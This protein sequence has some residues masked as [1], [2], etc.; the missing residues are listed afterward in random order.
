MT[1]T[2]GAGDEK[3]YPE[4]VDYIE[5][6]LEDESDAE[7]YMTRIIEMELLSYNHCYIELFFLE[8]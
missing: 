6:L 3:G 1:I 5:Q 2:S 4:V 7:I 8:L